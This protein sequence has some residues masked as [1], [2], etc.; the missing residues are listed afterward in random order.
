MRAWLLQLAAPLSTVDAARGVNAW[1]PKQLTSHAVR[2]ETRLLKNRDYYE[3]YANGRHCHTPHFSLHIYFKEDMS[4]RYGMTVSRKI[5]NAVARNR[6]KRL[7]REFFRSHMQNIRGW[8]I[9]AVARKDAHLLSLH[10]VVEELAPFL[11]HIDK[12]AS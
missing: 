8:Q 11:N 9:V 4:A 10:D 2:R 6:V 1:R 7:L 12:Y 5:G 3:C